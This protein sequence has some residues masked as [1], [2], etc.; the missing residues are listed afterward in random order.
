MSSPNHSLGTLSEQLYNQLT[1][2]K[3]MSVNLKEK[4]AK[5]K[6]TKTMDKEDDISFSIIVD[7]KA[8]NRRKNELKRSDPIPISS[9][10]GI[11]KKDSFDVSEDNDNDS[12]SND[13]SC[14][15]ESKIE[16]M[17]TAETPPDPFTT[18]QTRTRHKWVDD[19]NANK[20]NKCG[21][22]FGLFL[23]RHHCRLSGSIYCS[24]CC[25]NW[26]TIPESIT[27][28]PSANGMTSDIDRTAK[29]RLCD[30]CYEKIQ[31]IKKLEIILKSVKL[32]EMDL[33]TFKNIGEQETNELSNSFIGKINEF[34]DTD[35]LDQE[36]I[37]DFT[38]NYMNGKLWRQL[39]NFY[40]SK[41]REIQYKLPH[42]DYSEWERNV[43]WTNYKHL[44]GHDIW[45]VHLIRS[46]VNHPDKLETIIN[47]C[48]S[49]SDT[50]KEYGISI[51]DIDQCWDRMCTRLCQPTLS[52]ESSL[53]LLDILDKIDNKL[54]NEKIVESF[55]KCDDYILESILP[56]I[57]SHMTANQVLTDFV[58]DRGSKSERIATHIYWYLIIEKKTNRKKCE[59][60]IS[61]LLRALPE[62]I[63]KTVMAINEFVLTIEENHVT[64]SDIPIKNIATIG[65]CVSPTH[66]EVGYQKVNPISLPGEKSA[67]RPSP[68]SLS[69]GSLGNNVVLYKKEDLRTDMII[70]DII[71]I[72]K[73]IVED[74]LEMDLEIITYNIQPTNTD[75]GFIGAVQNSETFYHI[76]EKLKLS[77]SNYIKIK[78]P[79][80][81]SKILTERFLKSCAFYSVVTFLL[82][83]GD[84]HLDNIM[85]TEDGRMFHIDFG[86]VL[87]KDPKPMNTPSMRITEGMLDAIGGY[88][89]ESY[90]VFKDLCYNIYDILRRHVNTFVCMLNLLPKHNS[91]NTR[92]NPKISESRILREVIKRFAPGESYDQAKNILHTR[93]DR[94]TAVTSMSKYHVIDFFHRHNKEGTLTNMLSYTMSSTLS[95][96]QSVVGGIWD[97]I[98]GK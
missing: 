64:G 73:T 78:N 3:N 66:P 48:L 90:M 40:L 31:L 65:K 1:G 20:C 38:K 46:H 63:H 76:Q 26:D 93:I 21:E 70:M 53:M 22:K 8:N 12:D 91:G 81:S 43:M 37:L 74:N 59:Y 2:D 18:I 98:S 96:T 95:G 68:I 84:R 52:W 39:A 57:M 88:H 82:G 55:D 61:Q 47:Y 7:N 30:S 23:R 24:Y 79:E 35:K 92:T 29:V 86:F 11:S 49:P 9:P 75:A 14:D 87:G 97:Y 72:M 33:F 69:G 51:K 4:L 44:K 71:K 41:F 19:R 25:N 77:I 36:E 13:D 67:N 56:C 32:D 10:V 5:D 17:M 16:R 85:L 6:R 60:L 94:S 42:Q 80:T 28:I 83:I 54:L 34:P 58:M 45:I 15:F 50:E 62:K 27:Q 89:S